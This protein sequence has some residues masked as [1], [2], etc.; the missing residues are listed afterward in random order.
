MIRRP[1]RSEERVVENVVPHFR[2]T[3]VKPCIAPRSRAPPII[4]KIDP[5]FAVLAP[6]V[7]LPHIPRG[8]A[9][10]VVN[11]VHNDRNAVFV[12]FLHERTEPVRSA[13]LFLDCE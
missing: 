1:P 6:S 5:A 7:K 9:Q 11:N 12:C 8:T 10:V 3:V 4:V 2:P 13:I